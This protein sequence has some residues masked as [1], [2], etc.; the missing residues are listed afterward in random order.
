MTLYF[1]GLDTRSLVLVSDWRF[2]WLDIISSKA[3]VFSYDIV[4]LTDKSINQKAFLVIVEIS[5]EK[6]QHVQ[7]YTYSWD[8]FGQGCF[9]TNLWN[10]M[11][12]GYCQSSA[13]TNEEAQTRSCDILTATGD[14]YVNHS[15][16]PILSIG[17]AL[18]D[19]EYTVDIVLQPD[20]RIKESLTMMDRWCSFRDSRLR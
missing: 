13:T 18:P 17:Y 8:D 20:L 15:S 5:F 3:A 14:E 10:F 16:W 12:G 19:I 9:R 1:R 2:F 7:Y 6:E 11:S 4:Q